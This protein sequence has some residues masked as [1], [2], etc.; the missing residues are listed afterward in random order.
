MIETLLL[1]G[2]VA[3]R[4]AY[5]ITDDFLLEESKEWMLKK[6][7]GEKFNAYIS[8]LVACIYCMTFWTANLTYHLVTPVFNVLAIWAIA[9]L[10]GALH[11]R[12]SKETTA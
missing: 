11:N 12:F 6:I 1:Q 4:I 5:L 2:L 3:W 9:T 10:I 8:I 7:P